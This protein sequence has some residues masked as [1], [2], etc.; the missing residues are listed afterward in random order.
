M[1]TNYPNTL[2]QVA[3]DCPVATATI[4]PIRAGKKTIANW[5]YEIINDEPYEHTSDDVLFEV[6]AQR[7]NVGD[8]RRARARAR[9]EFF[10]KDQ[11]CLR[12]SPLTKRYG[13]GIHSDADGR[14]ALVAVESDEY[15][16][17]K[18][19]SN[20]AGLKAMRSRRA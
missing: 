15:R 13:W 16:A 1:T 3:D 7:G 9:D 8:E 2:I 10:S 12:A 5:Q 17:L 18:S 20:V 14:V 6:Y 11:P 4:P 19:D